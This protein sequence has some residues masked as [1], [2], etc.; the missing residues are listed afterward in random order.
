[1]TT[2]KE[3]KEW[4]DKFPEETEVQFAVQKNSPMWESYG[5]VD[6]EYP[7]LSN[8]ES[9]FGWEFEDFRENPFVKVG[10]KLH[11]KCYLYLGEKQ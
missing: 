4:L 2:V 8:N 1:M 10:D 3:L 5:R 7:D 6:F 11:G 9:G